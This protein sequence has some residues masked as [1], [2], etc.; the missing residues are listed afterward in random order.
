VV[1]SS[2]RARLNLRVGEEQPFVPGFLTGVAPP[3]FLPPKKLRTRLFPDNQQELSLATAWRL[4]DDGQTVLI[5]C[6]ERRSVEP[7]AKVIVDLHTRGA[8]ASLLTVDPVRLQTAIALGEE[9]LGADSDILKCLRLG[10]ALH[11]GALPTA[12]R[13]RLR[14]FC[15]TAF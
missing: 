3:L 9:W 15:E 14:G 7:F 11:H 12:Y 5:Y 1:W 4:V 8:L 13:K 2:P 10:V 6:P